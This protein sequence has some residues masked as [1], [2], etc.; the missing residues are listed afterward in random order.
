MKKK[1]LIFNLLIFSGLI[2]N[3]SLMGAEDPKTL[4]IGAAAPAFSLPGVDGK[5]YTLDSFKA[6]KI[7][8]IIFTANHCPTAQAYEERI[9]SFTGNTIPKEWN[10]Y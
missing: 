8:V 2:G 6:G 9:D 7:L 10:L 3:A 4:D 1:I 5:I